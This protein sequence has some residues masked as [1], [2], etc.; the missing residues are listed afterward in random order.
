VTSY[1]WKKVLRRDMLLAILQRFVMVQE[2]NEIKIIVDKHGREKEV[3]RN[4]EN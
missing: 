4:Q 3:P 1:L 2:E